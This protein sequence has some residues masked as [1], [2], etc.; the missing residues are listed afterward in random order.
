MFNNILVAIDGSAASERA[1]VRAVDEAKVWNAKLAAVYVVETGLFSSLPSDNTVE[2][3]Y[4]VLEKEGNAVLERARKY[5][6]DKG[7]TLIGHM[8]QGHAGSEVIAVAG[9]EKCDLIIVGSHGKSNADRLLIGS[10]STYIVAHSGVTTMVVR[11]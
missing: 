7:V 1:I 11:S 2:I 6:A 8:K 10:V 9:Q 5:A 3:M 4:S